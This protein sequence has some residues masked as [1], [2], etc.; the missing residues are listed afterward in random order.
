M[1]VL[2]LNPS[3]LE[4]QSMLLTVEYLSSPTPYLILSVAFLLVIDGFNM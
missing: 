1:W 2:G 4:G 3:H